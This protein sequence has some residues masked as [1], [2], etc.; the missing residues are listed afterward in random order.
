MS[1][2]P[3]PSR[4][5]PGLLA[6]LL[7][8]ASASAQDGKVE[9][10]QV[11]FESA[12]GA[13]VL[14]DFTQAIDLAG[15]AG[16]SQKQGLLDL[17]EGFLVGVDPEAPV[18]V[19][20]LTKTSPTRYRIFVPVSDRRKWQQDNLNYASGIPSREIAG[21]KDRYK[22]GFV[23]NAAFDGYMEYYPSESGPE[24][25]VIVEQPE[26]LPQS[27]TTLKIGAL[28]NADQ[29]AAFLLRNKVGGEDAVA[30]RWERVEEAEKELLST[31]QIKADETPEEFDL[32]KTGAGM[33]ISAIGRFYAEA[34]VIFAGGSVPD[35]GIGAVSTI[36]FQ[37][38]PGTESAEALA[39]IGERPARFAG[40]P[41]NE[42]ANFCGQ[43]RFPVTTSE[44]ARMKSLFEKMQ[45]LLNAR[46]KAANLPE[47]QETARLEAFQRMF[48]L[49]NGVTSEGLVEAIV[50][51]VTV[52]GKRRVVGAVGLP[53][54]SDVK[55]A[56]EAFVAS[57]E[58]RSAEYGVAEVAGV[59]L[60]R[61]TL[62]DT[63][64]G[65]VEDL[66]GTREIWIG[67]A[68][69]ALW[70]AAGPGAREELESQVT[71]AAAGGEASDEFLRMTAA[72]AGAAKLLEKVEGGEYPEYRAIAR[73]VL[74][75]CN[76]R[77]TATLR[78]DEAGY[79]RG[80]AIAPRCLLILMGRLIAEISER[81]KL[82][83]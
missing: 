45:A 76:G 71:A 51:T 5:V 80:R 36:V 46:T 75:A 16:A 28:L 63:F 6:L 37:P 61:L 3:R 32:R 33:Q 2:S 60:H 55:P 47:A 78:K 7:C 65:Y 53:E 38:L 57:R 70:Y 50:E 18:R 49:A 83:G 41:F 22:L 77:I 64:A 20:P 15:E 68:S 69:N 17:L 48:D 23:R 40:V 10:P 13:R 82:A 8:S 81:E 62:D 26:D 27:G 21:Q 44:Q 29:D 19:E 66:I 39:Q 25:A 31:L 1:R 56:L 54:G 24:Y 35:G 72:P 73:E 58:G 43:T 74:A 67:T 30:R 42:E 79:V 4:L 34:S 12:G 11:L 14:G 52:D 9:P 59:S